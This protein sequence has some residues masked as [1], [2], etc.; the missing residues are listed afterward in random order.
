MTEHVRQTK[1]QKWESKTAYARG[2]KQRVRIGSEIGMTS[3]ILIRTVQKERGEVN[4]LQNRGSHQLKKETKG[5]GL[6]YTQPTI[7]CDY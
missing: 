2:K 5:P 6:I 7:Y 3:R 4:K 1:Y